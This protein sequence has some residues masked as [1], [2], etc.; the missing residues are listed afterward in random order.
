MGF[1]NGEVSLLVHLAR[2][3]EQSCLQAG[4]CLDHPQL[5][6]EVDNEALKSKVLW[7]LKALAL[8]SPSQSSAT[9]TKQLQLMPGFLS[10]S[11]LC[12]LDA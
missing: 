1:S 4:F 8:L 6:K 10:N 12:Q 2:N 11:F 9:W 7:C 5:R 3:N